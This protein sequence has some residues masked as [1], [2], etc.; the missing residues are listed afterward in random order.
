MQTEVNAM[1]I[2]V[3]GGTRFMGIHTVNALIDDGQSVTIATRGR[4]RD[5]FGKKVSR[6]ICERTDIDSMKN[7]FRSKKYDVVCDSLA[8]VAKFY[9]TDQR[10]QQRYDFFSRNHQLYRIEMQMPH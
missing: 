10:S 4:V 1:N 8:C 3:L 7:A 2:L 6:I 5:D 9:R